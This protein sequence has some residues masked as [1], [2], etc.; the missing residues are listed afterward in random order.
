M[1]LT[2]VFFEMINSDHQVGGSNEAIAVALPPDK[3][4]RA[5]GNLDAIRNAA[6]WQLDGHYKH[7][8]LVIAT[9][10]TSAIFD[11]ADTA[12]ALVKQFH[13]ETVGK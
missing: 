5:D 2:F 6:L 3:Y 4:E 8:A 13:R 10:G 7:T 9:M 11:H 1:K 12:L